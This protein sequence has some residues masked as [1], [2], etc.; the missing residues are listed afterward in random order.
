MGT[1]FAWHVQDPGFNPQQRNSIRDGGRG[2]GEVEEGRE[3][4]TL[5]NEGHGYSYTRCWM[6]SLRSKALL[7]SSV[8]AWVPSVF[9]CRCRQQCPTFTSPFPSNCFLLLLV[10]HPKDTNPSH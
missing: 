5:D 10:E 6:A 1:V 4:G 8:S 3:E 2:R 7:D 9:L